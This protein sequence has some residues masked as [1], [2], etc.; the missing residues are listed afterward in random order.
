MGRHKIPA[1]TFFTDSPEIRVRCVRDNDEFVRDTLKREEGE[2]NKGSEKNPFSRPLNN[3]ER[4][5]HLARLR[6]VRRMYS[7]LYEMGDIAK[8]YYHGQVSIY[9]VVW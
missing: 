4:D 8:V 5:G 2:T 7:F 9:E 6:G 3:E 1:G